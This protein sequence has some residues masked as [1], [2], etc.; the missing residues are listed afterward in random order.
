MSRFLSVSEGLRQP[1]WAGPA[2]ALTGIVVLAAV[3]LGE[4]PL[5]WWIAQRVLTPASLLPIVGL[6]A[7]FGLAR[8]WPAVV[9]AVLYAGGIALGFWLY[10]PLLEPLWAIPNAA[11]NAFLTGPAASIAAGLVLIA[12]AR[13]R[14]WLLA[15]A[16]LVAGVLLALRIVATDP[17]LAGA[18]NRIAGVAIAVWL[19]ATVALTVRAFERI[20]FEL[21][22][23][24][25]GSWLVAIGLLYGGAAFAPKPRVAPPPTPPVPDSTY[26]PLGGP[27]APGAPDE[28][29]GRPDLAAPLPQ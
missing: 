21:A 5:G 7:A 3:T 14:A 15:P 6:G 10:R 18:T 12:G 4:A 28:G 25:L 20:W 2:L 19:I 26:A 29:A 17:S 22:G 27:G 13:S 24:I 1:R 11:D 16:A 9:S 8:G 23:R